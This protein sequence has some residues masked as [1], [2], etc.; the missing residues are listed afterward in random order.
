M[1]ANIAL[2][3]IYINYL[4]IF[5]LSTAVWTVGCPEVCFA[6][7]LLLPTKMAYGPDPRIWMSP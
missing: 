5:L 3:L 2:F 1:V 4:R 6:N 7:G